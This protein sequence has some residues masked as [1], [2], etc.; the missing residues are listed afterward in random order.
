MLSTISPVAAPAT[1]WITAEPSRPVRSSSRPDTHQAA[2][3]ATP[4]ANA[5]LIT[6]SSSR[7]VP[8][9]PYRA[10]NQISPTSAPIR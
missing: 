2:S 3:P 10:R 6:V 1:N 7:A 4:A 5:V 9:G 8:I